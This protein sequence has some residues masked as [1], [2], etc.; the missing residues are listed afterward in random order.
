MG[1]LATLESG[2][3]LSLTIIVYI[4]K[5]KT[6]IIAYENYLFG[7]SRTLIQRNLIFGKSRDFQLHLTLPCKILSLNFLIYRNIGSPM[8]HL[9][10]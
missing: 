4:F 10:P 6:I 7:N 5:K 1:C 2:I 3:I 9:R 8:V